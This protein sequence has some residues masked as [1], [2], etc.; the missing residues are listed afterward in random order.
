[1]KV[2]GTV[3][4]RGVSIREMKDGELGMVVSGEFAGEV[5]FRNVAGWHSL[6]EHRYWPSDYMVDK[7]THGRAYVP[8]LTVALFTAGDTLTIE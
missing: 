7:R 5:I 1:M 4:P 2:K 3:A 8:N 6:T